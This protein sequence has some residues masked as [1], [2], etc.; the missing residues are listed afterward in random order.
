MVWSTVVEDILDVNLGKVT[1]VRLRNVETNE[2]TEMPIDGVF[3]AIGHE[4][5][6]DFV[7]GQIELDAKGFIVCLGDSSQTSTE[8]VFAAGDVADPVYKQAVTAAA[9]GC[10]AAIDCDRY[11]AS[12]K[13]M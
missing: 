3:V 4:P 2:Q 1:G 11:L 13:R 9:S 6:T 7:K 5:N 12:L 10:R 8:G